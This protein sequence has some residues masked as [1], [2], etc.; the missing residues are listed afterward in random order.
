MS[1]VLVI[2]DSCKDVFVYCTCDRLA[3]EFPVQTLDAKSEIENGGMAKNV[4]SN[5]DS[6]GID[7]D[8]ATNENWKSITKTRYIDKDTNYMFIRVDSQYERSRVNINQVCNNI[9]SYDAVVVSDYDKGFLTTEDIRHICKQHP[10]TFIDT[11]KILGH[12]ASEA[13]FIKINHHEYTNSTDIVKNDK[14]LSDKIIR[15]MGPHGAFYQDQQF[16]VDRVE[17]KDASGAGDSFLAGLVVEYIKTG[18]IQESIKFGNDC[19]TSVV[20]KRGVSV[21]CEK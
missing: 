11:K 16:P 20:Q 3:P 10:C 6:L 1:R 17:V 21:V 19:A 5:I 2:G 7:C 12:W 8:I 9:K 13:K 14:V 4:Q 15:T 18:N